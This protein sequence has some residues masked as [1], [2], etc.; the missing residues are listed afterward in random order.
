MQVLYDWKL[1][2]SNDD[3]VL[4]AYSAISWK[5]NTWHCQSLSYRRTFFKYLFLLFDKINI[6][7]TYRTIMMLFLFCFVLLFWGLFVFLIYLF[8]YLFIVSL[9]FIKNLFFYILQNARRKS[10]IKTT[11]KCCMLF[12]IR[13]T[14]QNTG[15]TASYLPSNKPFK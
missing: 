5:I 12:C 1:S 2:L 14:L 3:I 13:S 9:Q 10:K 11:Q 6:L 7:S 8:I 4:L 15:C